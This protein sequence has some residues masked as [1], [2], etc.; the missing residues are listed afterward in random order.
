M[1]TRRKL[2]SDEHRRQWSLVAWMQTHQLAYPA[3]QYGQLPA[4][5]DLSSKIR[6][7]I[8]GRRPMW[9]HPLFTE[10]QWSCLFFRAPKRTADGMGR[11]AGQAVEPNITPQ[12][13]S[14]RIC[15]SKSIQWRIWDSLQGWSQVSP[16]KMVLPWINN[17]KTSHDET[18]SKFVLIKVY[19]KEHLV[20]KSWFYRS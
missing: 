6:G 15:I 4:V 19:F 1:L 11:Q 16:I 20:L 13:P 2:A 8:Y 14:I 18:N 7:S 10:A 12:K 3:S 5:H 17:S 9:D